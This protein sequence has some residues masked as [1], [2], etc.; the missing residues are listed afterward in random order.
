MKSFYYYLFELHFSNSIH[1]YVYDSTHHS[2]IHFKSATSSEPTDACDLKLSDSVVANL[3]GISLC[4]NL[5]L[6][7]FNFIKLNFYIY[8][9]QIHFLPF[10]S[11]S[12]SHPSHLLTIKTISYKYNFYLSYL[13]RYLNHLIY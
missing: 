10:L 4:G 11:L 5:S 13:F 9:F 8:L 1:S 3:D 6:V 7:N 12:M 2:C